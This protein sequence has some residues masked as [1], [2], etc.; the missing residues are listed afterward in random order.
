MGAPISF[1]SKQLKAVALSSAKNA[2]AS[3][4]R[5]EIVFVRHVLAD[6]GIQIKHLTFLF[7]DNKAAIEIAHN[8][9]GVTS[10]SKHFVA[11]IH[12]FVAAIH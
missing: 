5:Q 12:Y 6:L 1:T 7:V 8:L 2:A 9:Q 4:S 11:A 3:C 10:R